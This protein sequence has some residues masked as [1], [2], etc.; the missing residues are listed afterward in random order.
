[1]V[2]IIVSASTGMLR[3]RELVALGNGT[4]SNAAVGASVPCRAGTAALVV[5]PALKTTLYGVGSVQVTEAADPG[6]VDMSL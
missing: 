2:T 3:L 1:M 5:R 6:F 4:Y